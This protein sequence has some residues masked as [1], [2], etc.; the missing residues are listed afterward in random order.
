MKLNDGILGEMGVLPKKPERPKGL[1]DYPVVRAFVVRDPLGFGSESV[2]NFYD[3][4]DEIERFS[5]TEKKF[6]EQGRNDE[7]RKYIRS[8]GVE[9]MATRRK[10]DTEFRRARSDLQLFVKSGIRLWT[11]GNLQP[12]RKSWLWMN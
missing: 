2:Q 12:P 1:A 8:H 11:A 3:R 6:K 5:A 9:F 10:L 4:L 7:R